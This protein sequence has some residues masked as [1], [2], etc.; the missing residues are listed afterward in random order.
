MATH[1]GIPAI[2]ATC[3]SRAFF[4]IPCK[5]T[6]EARFLGHEE[7]GD[8][9]VGIF[10]VVGKC[11]LIASLIMDGCETYE[12]DHSTAIVTPHRHNN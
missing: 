7:T 2:A 10:D 3:N 12:L 5:A 9:S 1:L 6:V 8:A 4:D 11:N